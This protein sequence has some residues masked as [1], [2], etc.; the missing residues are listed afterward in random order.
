MDDSTFLF[1]LLMFV[2][3]SPS[4]TAGGVKTVTIAVL[5]LAVLSSV[6]GKE[7]VEVYRRTIPDSYVK[8]ALAVVG[9]GLMSMGVFVVLFCL[10]QPGDF[11]N[12][13]FELVSALGTVGLTRGITSTLLP[14]GKVLIILA[15][16]FGR[17]GP[18]TMALAFNR[19]N[20]RTL[21]KYPEEKIRVG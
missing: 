12:L 2:G 16:F 1:L 18:I 9:I 21:R 15:M 13:L 4:G 14:A 8:K 5:L 19:Q 11:L 7:D 20:A 6:K 17:V 10:I 3:G